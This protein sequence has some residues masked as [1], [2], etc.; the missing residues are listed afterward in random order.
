VLLVFLMPAL[1][2]VAVLIY[3]FR[4]QR[5]I[6]EAIQRMTDKGNTIT[7]ELL[8]ILSNQ[9]L[10]GGRGASPLRRAILLIAAGV[11]LVIVL[12]AEGDGPMWVFGAI[13]LLLGV[14]YLAIWKLEQRGAH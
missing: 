2:I 6:L 4:R 1:V 8:Q 13:P 7:P 5:L 3:R 12:L 14:A 9:D 10:L 11:S